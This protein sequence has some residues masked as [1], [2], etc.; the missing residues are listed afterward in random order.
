MR[1]PAQQSAAG[2]RVGDGAVDLS[3]DHERTSGVTVAPYPDL[4]NDVFGPVMQPGSS[5]HTAGPCRIGYLAGC[6]LGEPVASLRIVLPEGGSFAGTFGTMSE[7]RAIVAGVLG[8]PPD[9]ADLF[10]SLEI[11]AERGVRV[12]VERARVSESEHPNALK[13]VLAG[14]SGLMVELVAA[15]TGGGMVETAAVDGFPLH[16]IGDAYVLLAYDPREVLTPE[17]V[18]AVR[19]AL[20]GVLGTATLRVPGRGA[21]HVF[22]ARSEP[23]VGAVSAVMGPEKMGGRLALLRPLLPVLDRPDRPPQLFDSMMRWRELAAQWGQPLWEVAVRYEMDASGWSR[24]AVMQRMRELAALMHRQTH[25]AYD[26]GLPVPTSP[27]KPDFTARWRAHEV[28][29][30]RV[31]GELTA[32]TI[33]WAYGAGAGIPGVV[34]VSG[35]MGGGAGYIYCSPQRRRRGSWGERR[36]SAARP[37]RGRRRRRYRLHAHRADGRGH[38]L[39]R[40]GRC[41]RRDGGRGHRRD[42][43]WAAACGRAR[44]VA[45]AAGVHG[46]PCDP[47]PGGLSQP[48]RS[49][50]MAATCTAHVF[51]DL[52]LAGHDAVLPLH[53]ALDVA[54]A[55]GRSLSPEL[56]CTSVG[57]ACATPSARRHRS[58]YD[59]WLEATSPEDR[60]PGNLI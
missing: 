22:R 25:A 58:E 12:A 60:P 44:R 56:R 28:S 10:R 39:H 36:G 51:A 11:A 31:T 47:I 19:R 2:G 38:R 49:R 16:T 34:T 5:S 6:L 40:R 32:R 53:E 4:F 20:V 33:R 18:E 48:C 46:L 29:P 7:D 27:F 21:L 30:L 35:P 14:R 55:V 9:D 59:A 43:G 45:G 23:D 3:R 15:S 26:E 13:L 42:A 37:L 54:D 41:L 1:W 52:A 57:G 17:S 24:D 8:L 50:I